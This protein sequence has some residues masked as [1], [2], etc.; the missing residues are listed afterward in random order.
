MTYIV[1]MYQN[2]YSCGTSENAIFRPNVNTH[3]EKASYSNV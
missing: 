3:K 1:Q 2:L